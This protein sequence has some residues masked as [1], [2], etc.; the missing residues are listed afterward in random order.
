MALE[1]AK[2]FNEESRKKD[3]KQGVATDKLSE[4]KIKTANGG[5]GD[6]VWKGNG[7]YEAYMYC[8]NCGGYR[9]Y[10]G[11]GTQEDEFWYEESGTFKCPYCGYQ[12]KFTLVD[13]PNGAYIKTHY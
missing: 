13:G 11:S 3:A 9:E 8:S 12:Q 1:N 6:M 2:K 5:G 4:D 7:E 10:I